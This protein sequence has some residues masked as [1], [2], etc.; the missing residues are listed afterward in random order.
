VLNF[1]VGA[2]DAWAVGVERREDWERWCRAPAALVGQGSPRLDFLPPLFRRRCSSLSR[3]MLHVAYGACSPGR[4]DTLPT[5]F[6]S[7]YGEL[8]LTVSLLEAL[9][10]REPLSAGGFTHSIHNTQV[11]LFSIAAKNRRMASA[12]SAGADT[13]ACSVLEAMAMIGRA[14]EGPVLLVIADEPITPVFES[15]HDEPNSAYALGLVIQRSG[16]GPRV[17]LA[18][19][20]SVAFV[21]R[22]AWPQ[23]IEFLRWLL[24][25]EPSLT[26]GGKR[27]WTW[28]RA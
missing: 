27:P 16:I 8:A 6:A 20:R 24:S 10:R 2:W 4:V 23:P 7:R 17:M 12:L 14:G 21:S 3:L 22:P 25:D 9:A 13:F 11:G 26:L 15:F 19:A 5:V 18:P 1:V 28:M